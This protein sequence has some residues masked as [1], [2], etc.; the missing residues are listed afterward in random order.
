[1][2]FETNYLASGV[3]LAILIL[4]TGYF[5]FKVRPVETKCRHGLWLTQSRS[6]QTAL[7]WLV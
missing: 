6:T 2:G 5:L 3:Y 1:M 4:L 7:T